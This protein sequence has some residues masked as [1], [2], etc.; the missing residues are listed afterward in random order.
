MAPSARQ[1]WKCCGGPSHANRGDKLAV[2]LGSEDAA[3]CGAYPWCKYK[4][5]R[6]QNL[7]PEEVEKLLARPKEAMEAPQ[8]R[9]R[10]NHAGNVIAVSVLLDADSITMPG[11]TVQLEARAPVVV[12]SCLYLFSIMVRTSRGP[13]RAYQ[14]EVC[15]HGKRSH[16]DRAGPIFGPHEHVGVE[17]DDVVHSVSD[18]ALHCGDW[19]GCWEWFLR[20]CTLTAPT[21]RAP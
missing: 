12:D 9:P 11:F 13:R 17:P 2:S 15:P 16:N 14:L 4:K 10:E 6:E 1:L 7:T 20:R 8:W 5:N 21:M 19:Y 18:T 3:H